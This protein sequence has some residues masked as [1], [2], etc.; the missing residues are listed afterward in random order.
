MLGPAESPSCAVER[1][2][3]LRL[4]VRAPADAM[5]EVS[6]GDRRWTSSLAERVADG[7]LIRL[8]KVEVAQRE[9]VVR[10]SGSV[11][12]WRLRLVASIRPEV[13]RRAL[14]LMSSD[15]ETAQRQLEAALPRASRSMERA[16]IL[17][18]LAHI[19]NSDSKLETA[20]A[21]AHQEGF[22]ATEI[23]LLTQLFWL[24]FYLHDDLEAAQ[25]VLDRLPIPANGDGY[26]A[27][28]AAYARGAQAKNLGDARTAL[29]ELDAATRHARRLGLAT[30]LGF[31]AQLQA[32]QW[33]RLG[34]FEEAVALLETHEHA[35]T[36]DCDRA[37]LLNNLAW[38]RILAWEAG[39]TPT[40][41][42]VAQARAR[43]ED[44]IALARACSDHA[45]ASSQA[46]AYLNL[47]LADFHAKELERAQEHLAAARKL[48]PTPPWWQR[49]WQH[50]LEARIALAEDRA[51][52]ALE[53]YRKLETLGEQTLAP[54][55]RWRAWV[56]SA[57]ALEALGDRDAALAALEKSE[58]LADELL[59][60]TSIDAEREKAA[61]VWENGTQLSLE[62]LLRADRHERA[63]A[64][65][66]RARSRV[67]RGL[68]RDTRLNELSAA[69]Q[70]RWIELTGRYQALRR[71]L[72][73]QAATSWRLPGNLRHD[74]E[75]RR[76]QDEQRLRE[77]LDEAFSQL[78]GR[79]FFTDDPPALRDGELLLTYHPLPEG[80]VAFTADR[81]RVET[82]R[83][84]PFETTFESPKAL[85]QQLLAPFAD[86]I[87]K[88]RRLRV[89]PYG[90]LRTVDFHALPF[91]DGILL[92]VVP[93]VYGLDL[94][95]RPSPNM[96][97]S[98]RRALVVADPTQTLPAASAETRAVEQALSHAGWI[99]DRPEQGDA[100]EIRR[101]LAEVELFH[102]AGHA[103]FS[104]RGGWDSGL[105]LAR[106]S[107]LKLGDLLTSSHLP[108]IVVLSAC[109][110]NLSAAA[111]VE[112]LGLAT[113][114]LL[115][116]SAQVIG[117]TEPVDDEKTRDLMTL[118]YRA[119]GNQDDPA[120]ALR[121]AQLDLRSQNQ[122][123][124]KSFRI[125]ER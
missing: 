11:A 30:G 40:R 115:G 10:R 56:G 82:R 68:L 3:E 19:D 28:L 13:V 108:R 31:V 32:D 21:L 47:A 48:D 24:H 120:E 83:L 34:R 81:E 100:A 92:D 73:E 64:V 80:W 93:V 90:A 101:R 72:D 77:L 110:S 41:E 112:G 102:F 121:K 59:L 107:Q 67:L 57:R 85:S 60:L 6:A 42:T 62:L 26:S 74:F 61:V 124:W 43:L 35:L 45:V 111:G 70:K 114:F 49:I 38:H 96:P 5:I 95:T 79:D 27:Y 125:V 7:F 99:V 116:G 22:L 9:I 104:G 37:E 65:A 20:V 23:D 14:R 39:L 86:R 50:D 12:R 51:P 76:R 29:R 1:D 97:S 15:A 53:L 55:A 54:E 36:E 63:F 113:A 87:R 91:G 122:D 66:R 16:F 71:E 123:G 117:A 75:S 84:E 119:L 88:A 52:E 46:N 89:L 78:G 25:T 105:S 106:E 17:G 44:V 58:T 98:T 4:W 103:D 109:E 18:A 2:S 118:L 69:E 33:S 8:G 94:P